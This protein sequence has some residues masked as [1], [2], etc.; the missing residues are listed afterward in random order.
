MYIYRVLL[1]LVSEVYKHILT[2]IG[3]GSFGAKE[4]FLYVEIQEVKKTK[5]DQITPIVY[6]SIYGK[7]AKSRLPPTNLFIFGC[8]CLQSNVVRDHDLAN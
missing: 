4:E 2:K 3:L 1:Y 8:I 7:R 6:V 5:L